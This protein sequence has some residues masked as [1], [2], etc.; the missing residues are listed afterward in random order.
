MDLRPERLEPAEHRS[1]RKGA[2]STQNSP[3]AGH[4]QRMRARFRE[5][6]FRSFSEHEVLEYIL[7]YA[8]PRAD[9]NVLAHRLLRAFGTLRD[10]LGAAPLD[11]LQVEGVG[12]SAVDVIC[13]YRE[14]G[15]ALDRLADPPADLKSYASRRGY[16]YRLLKGENEE[17]VYLACLDDR[18]RVIATIRLADGLPDRVLLEQDKLIRAAVMHHC[19]RVILAHC[20]PRGTL[21]PSEQ[22]IRASIGIARSLQISGIMLIDHIIVSKEDALSMAESGSFVPGV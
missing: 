14:L 8:I 1:E 19:S 9:T 6:G 2:P 18:D 16:F 10:V 7:Y 15:G 4:R 5:S 21:Y 12:Q 13:M 22:D 11:L 3:H 20:H 17:A